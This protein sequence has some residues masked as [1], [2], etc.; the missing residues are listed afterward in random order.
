[1]SE[2]N[3]TNQ[4]Y[5]DISKEDNSYRIELYQRLKSNNVHYHYIEVPESKQ[6]EIDVICKDIISILKKN[7]EKDKE[8]NLFEQL[9][10][11]SVKLGNLLL[12]NDIRNELDFENNNKK[13]IQLKK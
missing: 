13:T 10:S 3:E 11:K 7:N 9:Y 12:S 5:L 2:I 8:N 4:I 6:G 1:M